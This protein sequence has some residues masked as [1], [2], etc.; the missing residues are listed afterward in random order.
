MTSAATTHG[1]ISLPRPATRADLLALLAEACE[2]EHGLACSYLY[3]A[4]SLKQ[5]A[6]E[7]GLTKLVAEG[8]QYWMDPTLNELEQRLDAARLFRVSRAALI[9][10][11]SVAEVFPMPGGSGEV[12][13]RNGQRLEVSRRRYREL[14][15]ALE[16]Q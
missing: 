16:G 11:N 2:L 7:G 14:I 13:L 8:A 9:N 4:F 12:L 1:T 3:A 15:Q 10:L 5:D 6:S